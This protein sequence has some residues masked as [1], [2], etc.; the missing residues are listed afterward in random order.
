MPTNTKEAGLENLIVSYL[1]DHHGYEQGSNDNYNSDY[2]IDE[3]RLLRFSTDASKCL[4]IL[5][6]QK[7]AFLSPIPKFF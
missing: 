1:V 2:A 6:V 5:R 7:L 3:V 4:K